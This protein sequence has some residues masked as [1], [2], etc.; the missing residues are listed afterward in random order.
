LVEMKITD[1]TLSSVFHMSSSLP[2]N[3]SHVLAGLLKRTIEE[4]DA[5]LIFLVDTLIPLMKQNN[6]ND[7]V[8]M[9]TPPLVMRNIKRLLDY[10]Q[11]MYTGP[12]ERAYRRRLDQNI[13]EIENNH[14]AVPEESIV[15]LTGLISEEGSEE[16]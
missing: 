13:L 15:T 9:Q 11:E 3:I 10:A 8:C 7:M 1:P 2:M 6:M 14:E 16:C 12:E 4:R 5:L